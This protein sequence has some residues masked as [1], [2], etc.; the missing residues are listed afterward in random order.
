MAERHHGVRATFAIAALTLLMACGRDAD[1]SSMPSAQDSANGAQ[2]SSLDLIAERYVVLALA[3]RPYDASYVDAYYGPDALVAEA[4]S[5]ARSV[6]AL[7]VTTDELLMVLD[8]TDVAGES[9]I[10]SARKN[11][12]QKRL[13]ALRLRL[14]MAQGTLL[15]FDEE[16]Q[17]LFDAEAPSFDDA[18]FAALVAEID[19]LVPGEG[20]LADRIEAFREQFVIP[21]ERLGPVFDAA[22][23]ECRRRTLER[24][25]LPTDEA[26]ELE[27]VTDQPWSGYNWYQGSHRSL[28]QINT[29]LPIYIDR[30]VDLGCHEGY[31]GHHTNNV[32]SEQALVEDRNWVEFTLG[33]LYGPQSLISE[34]SANFGIELAFPGAERLAFERDV[35]F[36]LAGLDAGEAASY[37]DLLQTLESLSYAGIEAARR[38]L[39]GEMNADQTVD[40]LVRYALSSRERAEQ[41]ISFFDTYRS[42]IINY[43]LGRDLI[44]EYID[45]AGDDVERRW[46]AFE[47]LL[48]RP[49]SPG[50]LL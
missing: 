3:S 17:T 6:D 8:G 36:P 15:P 40:W 47:E 21:T 30:A 19:T 27:F 50:D 48:S 12:L 37:H 5:Q 49:A 41:R 35:L 4:E 26:F 31:P 46:Q 20:A 45:A 24:I 13:R 29:D 22:I 25:E 23:A 34:G 18:Y 1:D 42:Y 11:G 39:N 43:S 7:I 44:E 33:P 9:D 28:I 16:S 32:L 38:Y 14:N 2:P 10:V